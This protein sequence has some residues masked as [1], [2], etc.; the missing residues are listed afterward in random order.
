MIR[1]KLKYVSDLSPL[2][3]DRM[4]SLMDEYYYNVTR[5]IFE[6]DLSEKQYVILLECMNT[7]EI[8]GFSTQMTY[9][10]LFSGESYLIL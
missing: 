6:R 10:F 7:S 3:K 5:Q 2:E 8:A 9:P 4:F 1:R